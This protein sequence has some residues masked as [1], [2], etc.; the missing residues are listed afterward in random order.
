[1]SMLSSCWLE[2][3]GNYPGIEYAPDM[4]YSKGYEP[5]TQYSDSTKYRFN[6]YNMAMR[7]PPSGTVAIGQ[8]DYKYNFE[9]TPEGYEAA[10]AALTLPTDLTEKE[11]IEGARL[12]HIYCAVC[13]GN[14]GGNDGTVS[15]KQSTLKPSW[16]NMQDPYFKTL[17]VGK[18]YHVVT[19]GKNNMGSYAYALTPRERW[20]VISY[21]KR[22]SMTDSTGKIPPPFATVASA[23]KSVGM[24]DTVKL[25]L[26]EPVSN[27]KSNQDKD[28]LGKLMENPNQ[29]TK[30]LDKK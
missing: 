6:P 13:H 29:E 18:I 4:Y 1:M 11:Q 7:T 30:N 3:G 27:I 26:K 8:L 23:T 25:E 14:E 17:P 24:S 21:A 19:Y 5:F 2:A 28:H 15:S 22:L 9:N 20:S 16:A 10:G 12:F